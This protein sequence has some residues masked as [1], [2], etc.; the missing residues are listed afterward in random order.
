MTLTIERGAIFFG[1]MKDTDS[2]YGISIL[3]VDGTFTSFHAGSSGMNINLWD[4][5]PEEASAV[6]I[7]CAQRFTPF[8]PR[9]QITITTS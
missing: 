6:T 1:F 8:G 3:S 7:R 4:Y 5:I 2:S 9:P